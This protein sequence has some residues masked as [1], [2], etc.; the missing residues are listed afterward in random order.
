MSVDEPSHNKLGFSRQD[1]KSCDNCACKLNLRRYLLLYFIYLNVN[2]YDLSIKILQRF[3]I[4]TFP[5]FLVKKKTF[6]FKKK[7]L[8]RFL[9]KKI[10]LQRYLFPPHPLVFLICVLGTTQS[11]TVQFNPW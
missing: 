2:R 4:T 10:K 8:Q 7:T 1:S 11:F 3:N 6:P 9:L 5:F